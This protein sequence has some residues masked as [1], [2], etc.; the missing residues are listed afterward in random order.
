MYNNDE[1]Q[2]LMRK[3]KESIYYYKLHEL[4]FEQ[5]EN[6]TEL[7]YNSICNKGQGEVRLDMYSLNFDVKNVFEDV[8][9]YFKINIREELTKKLTAL[10]F[11]VSET[12]NGEY[13][14]QLGS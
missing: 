4:V 6:I 13:L 9:F 14:I 11:V 3:R 12:L 7:L 5:T 10:G 2:A 1:L 8:T